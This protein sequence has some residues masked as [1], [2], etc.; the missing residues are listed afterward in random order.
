[1]SVYFENV[2]TEE[3]VRNG[4]NV[5][6][7]ASV[8][9]PA[10]TMLYILSLSLSLFL[11]LSLS[12]YIYI[13]LSLSLSISLYLCHSAVLYTVPSSYGVG[14]VYVVYSFVRSFIHPYTRPSLN[15]N[16]EQTAGIINANI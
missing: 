15:V 14:T 13:S 8:E 3:A 1:M 7:Y 16:R 12:L 6:L 11:S 2:N 5:D 9:L 4:D 10:P